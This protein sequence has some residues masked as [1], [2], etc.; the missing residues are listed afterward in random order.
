MANQKLY[1]ANGVEFAPT[2][3]IA[4]TDVQ[5][6][7]VEARQDA[8]NWAKG[9]GLGA[10]NVDISGGNLNSIRYTGFYMGINLANAPNTGWFY[11]INQKY[12]DGTWISQIAISFGSEN[13]GNIV[14]T[15]TCL[16]GVLF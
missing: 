10:T 15:R 7:I 9:Y 8:I 14:Y 2:T 12:T 3:D 11:I 1:H 5:S 4:S 16:S 6:A 13:T